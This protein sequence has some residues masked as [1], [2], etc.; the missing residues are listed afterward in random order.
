MLE[1][2]MTETAAEE[3]NGALISRA[4]EAFSRGDVE[5]AIRPVI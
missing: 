5:G 1:T 3:A 2:T 4:Y